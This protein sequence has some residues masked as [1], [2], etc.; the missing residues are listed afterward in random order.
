[1][2]RTL[3]RSERITPGVGREAMR[4]G[5]TGSPEDWAVV[6]ISFGPI[7]EWADA[8]ENRLVTAPL[9]LACKIH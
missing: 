7:P 1:M 5:T 8:A 6:S 3:C 4:I 9:L 2:S